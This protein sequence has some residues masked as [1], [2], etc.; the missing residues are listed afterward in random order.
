MERKYFSKIAIVS[1]ELH[2]GFKHRKKTG[3]DDSRCRRAGYFAEQ[4]NHGTIRNWR[5]SD[6]TLKQ[7]AEGSM[8]MESNLEADIRHRSF[9]ANEKLFGSFNS[10][11]H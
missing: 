11:A 8:T 10:P 3:W 5:T 6:M 7:S 2:S 4:K 1:D 9:P